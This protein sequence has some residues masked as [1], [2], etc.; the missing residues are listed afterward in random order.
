MM[1][2]R[3]GLLATRVQRTK[4]RVVAER[5]ELRRLDAVRQYRQRS[6]PQVSTMAMSRCS[7]RPCAEPM[8]QG[9]QDGSSALAS[10]SL[11]SGLSSLSRLAL[12]TFPSFPHP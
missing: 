3:G 8:G 6:E 7:I 12:P 10:S 5:C 1:L 4:A 9:E 11:P 2:E